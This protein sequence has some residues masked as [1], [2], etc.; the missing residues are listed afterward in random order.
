MSDTKQPVPANDV[1]TA[2]ATQPELNS[3]ADQ[4]LEG[5]FS[6]LESVADLKEVGTRLRTEFDK[7][8]AAIRKAVLGD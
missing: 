1:S 2:N 4:I 6:S 7:N 3:V 8:D 5:F